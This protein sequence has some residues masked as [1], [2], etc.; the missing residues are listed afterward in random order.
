MF[1]FGRP[2][3]EFWPQRANEFSG[4]AFTRI[5][6]NPTKSAKLFGETMALPMDGC[7]RT[8]NEDLTNGG[9]FFNQGLE[10]TLREGC[11]HANV[12]GTNKF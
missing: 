3:T 11:L 10:Y 1:G 9:M 6:R 8:W 5:V 12:N 7:D 2:N 4:P